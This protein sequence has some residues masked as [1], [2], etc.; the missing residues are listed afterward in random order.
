M[1]ALQRRHGHHRRAVGVGDNALGP[2]LQRVRV[3]LGHHQRHVGVLPPGRGVVDHDRAGGGC[4]LREGPAGGG[5]GGEQAHVETG[6]VGG[7]R[8]LHGDGAVAP[9]QRAPGRAGRGEEAQPVH[10][11]GALV[12][13]GAHHPAHLAGCADDSDIHEA[14]GYR[15]SPAATASAVQAGPRSESVDAGAVGGI[16]V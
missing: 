13:Q 3:D 16:L 7:G 1:E 4:L 6:V 10:R 12:Q 5:S 11:E 2:R 15:R 14:A 9:V 8:V